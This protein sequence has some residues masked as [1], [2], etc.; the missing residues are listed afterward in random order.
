MYAC[1]VGWYAGCGMNV[2]APMTST[3][4]A[5]ATF[6]PAPCSCLM[7]D[8]VSSCIDCGDVTGAAPPENAI[9]KK[10][11]GAEP[12]RRDLRVQRDRGAALG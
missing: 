4:L 11:V 1:S 6:E 10:I 8:T 3:R 12:H 2:A 7:I 5:T 9:F